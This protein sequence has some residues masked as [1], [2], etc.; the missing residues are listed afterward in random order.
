MKKRIKLF[1]TI[2]TLCFSL[3]VF[4]FGVF[5]ALTVTYKTTGTI[6]YEIEDV[7]VDIETKVYSSS[8]LYADEEELQAETLTGVL[9]TTDLT[10]VEIVDNETDKYTHK[11]TSVEETSD[12]NNPTLELDLKFSTGTTASEDGVYAYFIE[13]KITNVSEITLYAYLD[14]AE[15]VIPDNTLVIKPAS[16][17]LEAHQEVTILYAL[18]LADKTIAIPDAT[19]FAFP[20]SISTEAP[21]ADNVNILSSSYQ[22]LIQQVK[23]DSS[24]STKHSNVQSN[25]ASAISVSATPLNAGETRL[26][27]VSLK[28][29]T[30]T[31]YLKV[32]LSYPN[33]L[34]TGIT[35]N[36]TSL[37]LPTSDT[38][39]EYRTYTI[40]I[41]NTTT[42]AIDITN[43][44]LNLQFTEI[45]NLLQTGTKTV[46]ESQV[47]YSYVEMGTIATATNNEYIKWRY[48]SQDGTTKATAP[49]DG[50]KGYYVLE[51]VTLNQQL[52][53]LIELCDTNSD[54][55][56]DDYQTLIEY[57]NSGKSLGPMC[58]FNTEVKFPEGENYDAEGKHLEEELKDVNAHDYA[59][60][61]V[62]KYM[63]YTGSE[64][65]YKGTDLSPIL[66]IT[67][68]PTDWT[69]LGDKSNMCIDYNIDIV[70]D[71]VYKLITPRELTDLYSDMLSDGSLEVPSVYTNTITDT[72]WLL[73][74]AELTN[75][76][77]DT[78]ADKQWC[79]YTNY[80]TRTPSW[81]QAYAV[82]IKPDGTTNIGEF[83]INCCTMVRAAFKIG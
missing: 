81:L 27:E 41:K 39:K 51:T 16:A 25:Q 2:A 77:G 37:F 64:T 72:F 10:A 26:V 31:P 11:Y 35:V 36:S 1:A 6:S 28:N 12:T 44:S 15:L 47:E 73:S 62:R 82:S 56:I 70:N 5:S 68:F 24:A 57:I 3:A 46:G 30:T 17:T 23:V 55:E 43:L 71:V 74:T 45:Q 8:T 21:G 59:T 75:L 9:D 33:G 61:T 13:T 18:A 54:G 29:V 60:S 50:A 58:A 49:I 34:P 20:I 65:V 52:L 80:L 83:T 53:N 67:E 22:A 19:E 76:F 14:T 4:T 40:K 79:E 7:Y 66:G 48:I 42:E 78:D 32:E 63:N 69:G 38:E